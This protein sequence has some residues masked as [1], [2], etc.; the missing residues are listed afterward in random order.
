MSESA[1]AGVPSGVSGP[2]PPLPQI[3]H[4]CIGSTYDEQSSG[5]GVAVAVPGRMVYCL[6]GLIE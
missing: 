3:R 2:L 6:E 4:D 5:V 1:G